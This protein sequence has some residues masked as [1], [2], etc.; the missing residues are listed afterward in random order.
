MR[1]LINLLQTIKQVS[2]EAL[3][4]AFPLPIL[5]SSRRRKIQ[6]VLSITTVVDNGQ[7]GLVKGG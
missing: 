6:R 2:F 1:I 7:Y 5:F 3:A 4:T